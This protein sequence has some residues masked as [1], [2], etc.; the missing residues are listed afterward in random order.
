MVA[1]G[2]RKGLA[3]FPYHTVTCDR[4]Y[5]LKLGDEKD[6]DLKLRMAYKTIG[7]DSFDREIPA[8]INLSR[9]SED[10]EAT[11]RYDMRLTVE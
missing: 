5:I 7:S 8:Y 3:G 2:T 11:V 6:A 4:M 10:G 1:P 9:L